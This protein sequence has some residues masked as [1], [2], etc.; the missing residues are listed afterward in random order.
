MPPSGDVVNDAAIPFLLPS[1]LS[2]RSI[3]LSRNAAGAR[4]AG[5]N[6]FGKRQHVQASQHFL[7]HELADGDGNIPHLKEIT[8]NGLYV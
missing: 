5:R 1:R 4:A 7:F 2:G 3:S 8:R 6:L